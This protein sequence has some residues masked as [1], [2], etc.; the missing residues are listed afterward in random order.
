MCEMNMKKGKMSKSFLILIS[1][2]MLMGGLIG[3]SKGNTTPASSTST[4]PASTAASTAP[5]AAPAANNPVTIKFSGWG[6]PS[7][8]E[9]FTKLIKSFEQKNPNIKVNY[10]H[11][12]DDYVGKM[13]TILAGGGAPDV[14][15]VPD[16]DFGR[17]VSQD[18]LLPIDDMMK[19][20]AI[21]TSDMWNSALV[22]YRYN[23]SV[24]GQGKLYALPKDIGP[25]VL[26]YNKDI[27]T[28]RG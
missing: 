24:T 5:T 19:T 11:I 13:N 8:K 27:S 10:V 20:G 22:R 17:W 23:G 1:V 26:Y 6:D 7:E 18:L 4:A 15:Y 9:V 28:C 25:T 12:P 21:D 2:F 16:G 14:F 3:C